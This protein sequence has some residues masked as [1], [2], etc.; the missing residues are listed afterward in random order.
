MAARRHYEDCLNIHRRLAD[1]APENPVYSRDLWVIHN[2]LG[3]LAMASGDPATAQNRF[4]RVDWKSPGAST[5]PH[6]RTPSTLATSPPATSGWAPWRSRRAIPAAARAVSPGRPGDPTA[7]LRRR[8]GERRLLSRTLLQLQQSGQPGEVWWRPGDPAGSASTKALVQRL[9]DAALRM[10]N[11][12]VTWRPATSGW[13]TSQWPVAIRRRR[14]GFCDDGWRSDSGC[15][16]PPHR[17]TP[18][19]L[20]N[21]PS[22]TT[23]SAT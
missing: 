23:I 5:S 1:A 3:D 18:T 9:A 8:T 7:P 2:M 15:S 13:A 12:R 19:T 11:T 20:A 4:T 14:G 22:A 6:R 10:L 17:R 21:S 16:T